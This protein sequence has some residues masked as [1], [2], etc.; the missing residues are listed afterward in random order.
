MASSQDPSVMAAALN[1]LLDLAAEDPAA[2]RNLVPSFANIFKQVSSPQ[3]VP[4]LRVFLWI[5]GAK[6]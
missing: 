4:N 5:M 3:D 1:P 2:F 6:V